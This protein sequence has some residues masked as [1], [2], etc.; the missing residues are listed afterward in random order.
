[1]QNTY[2][3]LKEIKKLKIDYHDYNIDNSSINPF[4]DFVCGQSITLPAALNSLAFWV[5]AIVGE[6]FILFKLLDIMLIEIYL[7]FITLFNI[8]KILIKI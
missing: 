5:T 7:Y 1:M 6:G 3:D 4:K 2:Q 8:C